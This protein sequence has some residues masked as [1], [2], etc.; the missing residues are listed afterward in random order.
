MSERNLSEHATQFSLGQILGPEAK[1]DAVHIAVA[2]VVAAEKLWPGQAIG[3]AEGDTGKAARSMTPLGIVDPFLRV[4]V[5]KGERCWMFLFPNT[6]TGLRHEW[7]HPG[8]EPSVSDKPASTQWL[9][10]FAARWRFDYE[11]LIKVATAAPGRDGGYIVAH[12]RDLHSAGELGEDRD[13]FWR[14]IEVLTG[15]QYDEAHRGGV[16]WTCSC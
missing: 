13:L 5:E 14:H 9:Q 15:R 10:A 16:V 12:G 6:I 3:P 7:T 4:P 2:P 11:E 8:F 1:R